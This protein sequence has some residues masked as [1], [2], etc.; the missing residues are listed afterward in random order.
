ENQG[1]WYQDYHVSSYDLEFPPWASTPDTE[2]E[3]Q[4]DCEF[5]AG[6][7]V[8]TGFDYLGEPTPY[9]EGTP[10]KSSYFGIIDLAGLKKDRFYLYQSKWSDTPVLHLL[11]HWNWPERIGQNVPVYCY[12]NY[13]A[14][15][16]FVNGVSMGIKK[17]DKS[18]KYTRYRLMW[19]D[20]VYQP[21][22]IKVVAL[23]QNNKPVAEEVILTSG[24]PFAVRLTADRDQIKSDGNDLSFV[25][26]EILDK[27]GNLCPRADNLLFFT[28]TGPGKLRAVCNGNP[29]DQTSFSSNY[30]RAFNGKLVAVI[31]PATESGEII[32]SVSGGKLSSKQLKIVANRP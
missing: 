31:E 8:W 19:N 27:S 10:A 32:L 23:D 26:I 12:T 9:N 21:G 18:N 28:V 1:P 11:P 2:F 7:F 20:V 29:I 13:P 22:E 14:A 5:I 24:E 6:E 25:T 15:E 30:M 3:M 17:K 4:D 16:L